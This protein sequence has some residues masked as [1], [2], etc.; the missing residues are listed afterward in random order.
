MHPSLQKQVS[1]KAAVLLAF[2]AMYFIW[3]STYLGIRFAIVSM[4]PLLMA[5]SRFVIAGALLFS[6]LQLRG[7][8]QPSLRDWGISLFVGC[9]LFTVGN[10]AIVLGEQYLSSGLV[11]L[12]V[13]VVPLLLVLLGW[14]GGMTGRPSIVVAAGVGAGLVGVS[15]LSQGLVTGPVA[16]PGQ[17]SLGIVLVL[18][19]ALAFAIGSLYAKKKKVTVSPFLAASMQMLCGGAVLLMAGLMR[20]EAVGL[21]LFSITAKSWLAFAYLIIFGSLIGF[22]A[23]SWLLHQVGTTLVGTY[24]FVNPAV[25]VLLGWAFASERVSLSMLGSASLI[26]LAVVLVVMGQ[27]KTA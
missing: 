10:G 6:F 8:L 14:L 19:S 22:S 7:E 18:T 16:R 25:A 15:L 21:D 24:A 13:A 9:C 2:T 17:Q 27:R 1:P 23:Y 12:L 26:M 5:G 20:G 4:P 11:A 3:G